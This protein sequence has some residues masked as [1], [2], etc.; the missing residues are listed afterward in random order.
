MN[1]ERMVRRGA[2]LALMLVAPLALSA[3]D[4]EGETEGGGT[5]SEGGSGATTEATPTPVP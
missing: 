3:C 4:D 2:L 5:T 1:T